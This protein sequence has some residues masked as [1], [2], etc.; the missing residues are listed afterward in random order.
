MFE[1]GDI[2]EPS[3]TLSISICLRYICKGNTNCIKS[4]EQLKSKHKLIIFSS[5]KVA[6]VIVWQ[7]KEPL[8]LVKLRNWARERMPHYQVPSV[9]I[10]ISEPLPRNNM[11][12]VNKKQIVMDFFPDSMNQQWSAMLYRGCGWMA[13]RS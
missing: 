3:E 10:T 7:K 12:K 5:L 6:A 1:G 8:D 4:E 9:A 11:G 2:K 13:V